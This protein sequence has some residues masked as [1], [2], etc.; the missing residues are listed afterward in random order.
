MT[1]ETRTIELLP[2]A[3]KILESGFAELP[4]FTPIIQIESIQEVLNEAASRMKDNYPYHHPYYIGQMLKPPHPVARLAY[5]LSLWIN[6]NNHALD[7][8]RASSA[9]EKEAVAQIA[10]MFGW[11]SFV[12]HLCSGGTMANLE[13]LWISGRLKPDQVVL[14]SEQAHYTHSRICS[15]LK[16]PFDSVRADDKAKMS[17]SALKQRLD[18]GNVGTVVVTLG[19][20]ATGSIDPLPEILEL[21]R[22]Y[23]FRIHVD[24]AYGGYFILL[25]DLPSEIRKAYDAMGQAD[26]IVIDPHKHGLQPYG[27]GCVIFKDP[28]VGVYYK[29]DSPYTYFTSSE[30][31]LGEISLECSRPGSSAVALWATQ[32]M[33]PMVKGGEFAGDLLKCRLAALNFFERIESDSRFMTGPRPELDIVVWA[34]KSHSASDASRLADLVFETAAQKQ[35][36][37][38]KA[39][40]PRSLFEGHWKDFEWNQD[41]I[42]C[43]RSVLMKPESLEWTDRIWNVLSAAVNEVLE[44]RP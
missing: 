25:E 44:R 36:H 2:E 14:A 18:Q 3:L 39:N 15:V 30:L 34:V 42:T 28:S 38:A 17:V 20:T 9:M 11:D 12:G 40:L 29:H 5:I 8:G 43:L 31:H 35:L 23:G 26:S 16:I 21:Q 27:C 10:K 19:T 24:A 41:H 6:P 37:L 4:E 13:A 32:K 7:G 1:L 33:L 22:F